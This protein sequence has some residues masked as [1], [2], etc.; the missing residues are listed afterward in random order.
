MAGWGGLVARCETVVALLGRLCSPN[1]TQSSLFGRP[2]SPNYDAV[3]AFG[4]AFLTKCTIVVAFELLV[5]SFGRAF[6]PLECSSV[7]TWSL[8]VWGLC[9]HGAFHK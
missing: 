2:S 8:T 3:V 4:S 1:A 6:D 5:V 7:S 9:W